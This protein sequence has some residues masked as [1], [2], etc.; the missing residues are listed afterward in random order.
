MCEV[1][2]NVGVAIA[3][4][5]A[6]CWLRGDLQQFGRLNH[7]GRSVDP[8]IRGRWSRRRSWKGWLVLHAM[9]VVMNRT[10]IESQ[11]VIL[12]SLDGSRIQWE[13]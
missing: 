9:V 5:C 7:G 11:V 8:L 1:M 3:E 2:I 12:P 4:C 10:I 13:D 6:S